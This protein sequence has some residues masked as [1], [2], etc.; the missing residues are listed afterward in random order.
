MN[1]KQLRE[2]I[3][4]T[5]REMLEERQSFLLDQPD[6]INEE[7]LDEGIYDKGILKAVFTAGGPGSGKSYVADVMFDAREAGKDKQFDAASFVGRYGLKYVNSDNLFEIGL[8]KMGIPLADLGAI[9]QAAKEGGE[10][11]GQDAKE[12]AQQIGLLGKRAD[13]TRAIAKGKLAKLQGYYA[14]GRLGMLIDGTGKDYNKMVQKRQ[15]LIDLGYDTYMIFV[16]TSLDR[17]LKQNAKRERK[18]DPEEVQKMW[19]QV[20]DNKENY[21]ELFGA[22]NFTIVVNNEPVPPTKEAT[23]SVQRFAE[24]PVENPLGQSWMNVQLAAKDTSGDAPSEEPSEEE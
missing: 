10:Y 17:A 21:Q 1:I 15:R 23:R 24:A 5:R 16:D 7:L 8:K 3:K 22:N 13:S 9:S 19:Q 4:E 18:L 14:A 20:Q 2:L 12:L 6:T 11:K